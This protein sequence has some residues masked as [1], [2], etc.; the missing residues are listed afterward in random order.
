MLRFTRKERRQ[1]FAYRDM[2]RRVRRR[3]ARERPKP[4]SRPMRGRVIDRDHKAAVAQ[5]FCVAT[6]IRSGIELYGVHVAHIRFS[7]AAAGARNAGL[8]RKPDDRWVLPLSPN[9]HRRQHAMAEAA[10][11]AELQVD[12]HAIAT[13]LWGASPNGDALLETLRR[14]V[15]SGSIDRTLSD[16]RG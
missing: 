10:Y 12:P 2:V 15:P 9:E 14:A 11:W 3:S 8:Q 7:N 4:P 1:A 5:L 16:A 13:A 6:F